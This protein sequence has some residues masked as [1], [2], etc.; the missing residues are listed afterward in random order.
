MICFLG[1]HNFAFWTGQ[2]WLDMHGSNMSWDLR[3]SAHRVRLGPTAMGQPA[4]HALY[5]L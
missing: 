3:S 1:L 5:T 2:N 4:L